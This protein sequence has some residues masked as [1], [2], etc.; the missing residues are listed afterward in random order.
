MFRWF[1]HAT[2]PAHAAADRSA[3]W[4]FRSPACLLG[5][6]AAALLFAA[7]FVAASFAG[8]AAVA[9]RAALCRWHAV[10]SRRAS[11]AHQVGPMLAA[12]ALCGAWII[13]DATGLRALFA[14]LLPLE[15][16]VVAFAG[17]YRSDARRGFHAMMAV[18]LLSIAALFRADTGLEF[19]FHWESSRSPAISSSPSGT[20]AHPY[21]LQFLP[22]SPVSAFCLLAD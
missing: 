1:K 18:L 8:A 4:T 12:V 13:R 7:G 5:I 21:V 15:Q 22:F 10:P 16:A 11:G 9:V 14:V 19:F 6:G 2:R 17:L 20:G 3:E